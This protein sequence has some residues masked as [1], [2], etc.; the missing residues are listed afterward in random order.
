MNSHNSKGS[1]RKDKEKAKNV[2]FKEETKK[3]K[4]KNERTPANQ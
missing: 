2:S 4:A 3:A 1:K